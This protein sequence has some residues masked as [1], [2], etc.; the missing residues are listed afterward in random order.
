MRHYAW[1]ENKDPAKGL[2]EKA[3]LVHKDFPD[4]PRYLKDAG[5]DKYPDQVVDVDLRLPVR[6]AKR[7]R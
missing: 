6:T 2:S 1:K 5:L 4:L 3:E 7:K